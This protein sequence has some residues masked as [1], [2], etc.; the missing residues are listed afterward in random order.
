MSPL[1]LGGLLLVVAV[2]AL[3]VTAAIAVFGVGDSNLRTLSEEGFPGAEA[4]SQLRSRGTSLQTA[5]R[6]LVT[7]LNLATVGV[8]AAWGWSIG[9]STG[10]A[11]LVVF[12]PLVLTATE[13][14]PRAF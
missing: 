11:T 5:L 13:I 3:L 10:I 4:L 8:A 12:V 2:S 1:L 7:F 14:L 6:L 9:Q